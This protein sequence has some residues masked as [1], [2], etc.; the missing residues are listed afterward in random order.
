MVPPHAGDLFVLFIITTSNP[1]ARVAPAPLEGNDLNPL[2][3]DFGL[4]M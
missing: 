3:Q 1:F 2:L 4:A